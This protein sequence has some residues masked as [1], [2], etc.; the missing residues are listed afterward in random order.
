MGRRDQSEIRKPEI[1]EHLAHVLAEEGLANVTLGKVAS[2]MGVNSGLLVHYFRSKQEMLVA[3][4]DDM[5]DRYERRAAELLAIRR[6]PEEQLAFILA[7]IFTRA[8]RDVVDQ[9]V[10]FACYYLS[11]SDAR[12]RERLQRM[13]SRFRERL[14]EIL[15]GLMDAGV[16]R[17][18][19]PVQIATLIIMMNEGFDLYD[20][21][22]E[23]EDCGSQLK[24]I[25]LE[26]LK[27]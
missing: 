21:I 4:V 11:L 1:L 27:K 7:N 26:L 22:L 13:F 12:I 3:L 19:D 10:F 9:N 16:I 14:A 17:R 5:L 15:A 20:N 23:A 8:W 18:A 25:V 24:G 6:S 2:R